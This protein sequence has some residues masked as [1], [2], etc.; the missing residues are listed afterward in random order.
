MSRIFTASELQ[1]RSLGE[2]Q[3]LHHGLRLELAQHAVGSAEYREASASLAT[4]QR[5][6]ATHRKNPGPR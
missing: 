1:R 3:A 5:V 4:L 2:L 6:I